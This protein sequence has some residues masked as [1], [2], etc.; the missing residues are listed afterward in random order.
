MFATGI[1]D[2]RADVNAAVGS[3]IGELGGIAEATPDLTENA[4]AFAEVFDTDV[5]KAVG[6]A[7]VLLRSGLVAD[8]EE[9]FDLLTAGMQEV[10][11]SLRD[12]LMDATR[13]YSQFFSDL[14]FSGEEMFA[15]LSQADNSFE[16]DKT[17][18]AIK[19]LAI[20]AADGST[21]TVEA[22]DTIGLDAGKMGDDILAGGDTARGAFDQIVEGLLGIESP[23]QR[24]QSAVAL[25]G[26]PIE[27][28]G[29][30]VED[31]LRKLR[32]LADGMGDTA[33]RAGEMSDQF[34]DNAQTK[35]Q[36]YQNK[37]TNLLS[38]VVE[39]PGAL[40]SMAT[41]VA[42]MGAAVQPVAPMMTGVAVVFQSQLSSIMSKMGSAATSVATSA[43]SM[44]ASGARWAA[45]TVAQG[46]KALASMVVTAAQ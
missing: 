38:K 36:G 32:G 15:M 3:I 33:G 21:A 14:G 27:D 11:P 24:A 41:A 28:M 39:A 20:R 22:F 10:A 46:A 44:I 45:Q 40:G 13:E 29:T 43:G 4:L 19:E 35:I 7:G 26:T 30:D 1:T 25:F 42:G 34:G 2:S 18:D 6:R 16:L 12:E 37:V 8:G 23:S 5:S 9:A 17:G 31:S